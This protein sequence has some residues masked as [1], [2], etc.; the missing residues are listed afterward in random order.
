MKLAALIDLEAQLLRDR[1]ADPAALAARDRALLGGQPLDPR[2]PHAALETW[3]EAVRAASADR[4]LP[5]RTVARA[6]AATRALLVLAGAVLGW[7][8]AAVVLRFEG[9]HPVNVWDFL[10]VFVALQIALLALLLAALAFPLASLGVPLLGLFRSLVGA[11]YPRLA[12]RGLAGGPPEEWRLLFRRLR[13]RRSLYREIEPWVLLGLAQAFGVAFNAGVILALLRFVVFSDVAFSWSTTL[14]E[15]DAGRFHRVVRALATPWAGLWP[16]AVPSAELVA[17]TR[18]S[19]LEGAYFLSGTGRAADP[20]LVGGWWPFLLA[21]VICY[22]LVPRAV[23]LAVAGLRGARLL[24]RLP[25]DDV[26]V[27]GLLARLAGGQ[28]ETA[29]PQPEEPGPPPP[30]APPEGAPAGAPPGRCPLVVWRD[31]PFGPEVEAAVAAQLGCPAAMVRPAG[32]RG[33]EEGRLDWLQLAD[34]ADAVAVLAEAWEAPD[35]GAL[36]LLR[37]LREALGRGRRIRVLLRGDGPSPPPAE[38][39]IW[40]EELAR[41]EDPWLSVEPLRSGP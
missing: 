36:R 32:G 18:Y 21:A 37:R 22:G 5:G 27:Q 6:L 19:R 4:P 17:S 39:R 26:E 1:D 8:A 29:S 9:P 38:V 28:V 35:G 24:A 12:A 14:L 41:L 31:A 7:A 10:L 2:R 30:P 33:H 20:A 34:G 3:V 15:L 25:F 11:V 16:D 23:A 40:K 13:G